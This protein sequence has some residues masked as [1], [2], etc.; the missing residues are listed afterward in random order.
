M[1]TLLII[2]AY[3]EEGSI[4]RVVRDII[5]NYPQFDYV[6]INDGS[7]DATGRICQEQGFNCINHPVNL[8]LAAG[9][10]TG[11][12][13]AYHQDYDCAIQFDGDGQ[14]QPQYIDDMVAMMEREDADIVIGSR[15]VEGGGQKG[16]KALGSKMIVASVKLTTG[17]SIKDPTSG[18]RLINRRM[19]QEFAFNF[20]YIPE[21][22]T[23]S[24][25]IKNGVKVVECPVTMAERTTG[26]SY[27]NFWAS[28]KYMLRTC[29]SILLIQGFRKRG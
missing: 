8:G 6:V 26:E 27:L 20:N 23:I 10:Q 9:V 24:F 29:L 5:D 11:L 7:S 25:L 15:F 19:I 2:P 28:G 4:E 14:H 3:N 21:P 12:L 18:M 13:Y 22:D 16:L 17:R 1:R